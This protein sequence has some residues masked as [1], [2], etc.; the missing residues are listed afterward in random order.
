MFGQ[1]HTIELSLTARDK[2][3]FPVLIGRRF[4]MGKFI[5]DPSK[6]DLSHKRRKS[7]SQ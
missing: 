7:K 5:V 6:Y 3:R 1:T 2:M 4:L